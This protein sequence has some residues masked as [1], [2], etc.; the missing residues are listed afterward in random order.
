MIEVTTSRVD[1]VLWA[2]REGDLGTTSG[3]PGAAASSL[4]SQL[5]RGQTQVIV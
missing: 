3:G 2:G 5:C 4:G 1:L